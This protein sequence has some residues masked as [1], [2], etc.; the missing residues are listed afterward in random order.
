MYS[1]K[2]APEKPG[3]P[4][5]LYVASLDA[6]ADRRLVLPKRSFAAYAEDHLLF[7]E[8]GTLFAQ[9]FD[10]SRAEVSGSAVPVVD[11]VRYF[12]PNGNADFRAGGGTIAYS[13]P[14]QDDSPVWVDRRGAVTGKLG[15]PGQ[16]REPRMSPDGLRVA[17][18]RDDRR[19]STGDVW[20][21]DLARH[22]TVRLT[23]D[24]WSE[25]N[26]LWSHDGRRIAFWSD[27]DGPPDIYEQS[28]DASAPPRRLYSTP[29]ADG[30]IGWLPGDRLLVR[31]DRRLAIVR[32]DGTIDESIKD[33]PSVN[34]S[35][36][37]SPDGR[38][39]ALTG[40]E[41]GV[42]QIYVQP[43]GRPGLRVTVAQGGGARP[44]WSRDGRWLYFTSDRQLL[45]CAVPT[46]DTFSNAPRSPCSGWS[47]ISGISTSAQTASASS[48]ASLL[49]LISHRTACSSTGARRL[50]AADRR[51]APDRSVEGRHG[52]GKQC[53]GGKD[54]GDGVGRS[55]RPRPGPDRK[56]Q[57]G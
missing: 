24:V 19:Q 50:P 56:R 28:T 22:T 2:L 7:V 44:L 46:G 3:N 35:V 32:A 8:D 54:D 37:V 34:A 15:D 10:L 47:A 49:R 42:S 45:Q 11:G 5:G 41:A 36:S 40:R 53:E 52:T 30:A 27:R 6:P 17:Y 14:Y 38:W 33:L 23:N 13:T 4:D 55:R 21:Q 29:G 20:L 12:H 26:L 43:L 51:I 16:Y 1:S 18:V 31:S 57:A 39:I 25:A 9:R 48:S